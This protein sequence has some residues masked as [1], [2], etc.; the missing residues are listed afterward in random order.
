MI[1]TVRVP[2]ILRELAD[3]WTVVPVEVPDPATVG[4]VFD[5]LATRFPA[6]EW[7]IRDECGVIRR[8]V[9]VFVGDVNVRDAALSATPAPP[10]AEIIILPAISGGSQTSSRRGSTL[11]TSPGPGLSKASGPTPT[12]D[13]AP[14]AVNRPREG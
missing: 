11:E 1:V 6:L 9:N 4:D 10:G 13:S 7:R 3:G 8:H 5:G 2:S 12:R 14:P